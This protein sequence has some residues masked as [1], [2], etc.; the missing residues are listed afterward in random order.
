M[1]LLQHEIKILTIKTQQTHTYTALIEKLFH[2]NQN[3]TKI[4]NPHPQ[5]E[6]DY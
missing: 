5:K 1:C 2:F 6:S 4:M 3:S